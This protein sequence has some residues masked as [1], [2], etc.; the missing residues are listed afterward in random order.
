MLQ[1]NIDNLNPEL[2][3]YLLE[4]LFAAGALDAWLTPIIMKKGRPG[5]LVSVLTSTEG[6]PALR[7]TLFRETSTLGIRT[8]AAQRD[9][10]ERRWERVETMYGPIRVKVGLLGGEAVNRAPEYEECAAAARQHGVALKQV[11][12]AALAAVPSD[13]QP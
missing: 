7:E 1:C 2:Y 5:I 6:A 3:P 8:T 12:A 10:L 4:Q 13:P 9:R 11:Y